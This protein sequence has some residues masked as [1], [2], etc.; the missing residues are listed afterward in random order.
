MEAG[1]SVSLGAPR[2]EEH[3]K[4]R[5]LFWHGGGERPARTRGSVSEGPKARHVTGG[6]YLS[7]R[8]RCSRAK[9]AGE[10]RRR[11]SSRPGSRGF[12]ARRAR[13]QARPWTGS[14]A[15]ARLGRRVC[16]ADL[17][18]QAPLHHVRVGDQ[19]QDVDCRGHRFF[20]P[21]MLSQH[22][23]H[24][25]DAAVGRDV[26]SNGG[27]LEHPQQHDGRDAVQVE[28]ANVGSKRGHEHLSL[29]Q[30]TRG[31]RG[32]GSDDAP[33]GERARNPDPALGPYIVSA[34][35]ATVTNQALVSVLFSDYSSSMS[36]DGCS[37]RVH[38]WTRQLPC[39]ERLDQA[40][41]SW[42]TAEASQHARP[43][44]ARCPPWAPLHHKDHRRKSLHRLLAP[45]R[46]R[47]Q[48][49]ARPA[50]G[51]RSG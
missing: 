5:G 45:S 41:R 16:P 2:R 48:R 43:P 3:S 8:R 36:G 22:T 27:L 28:E 33:H 24:D 23:Q 15:I 13:A 30:R 26:S 1:A 42:P 34:L 47:L 32:R 39:F 10:A 35:A 7:T 21:G 18:L 46:H 17:F 51:C 12:S 31:R 9:L 14:R 50:P 49:C 4:N 44:R 6:I 40:F 37:S 25:E 38:S 11:S 19:V 29:E 20:L